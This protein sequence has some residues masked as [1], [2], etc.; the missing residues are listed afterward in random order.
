MKN[1]IIL[2]ILIFGTTILHANEPI[3][4]LLK[5]QYGY[6][7]IPFG[8]EYRRSINGALPENTNPETAVL[9]SPNAM[10]RLF[11]DGKGN[12][13]YTI[14]REYPS[15]IKDKPF[16]RYIY[17]LSPND[18]MKYT[19]EREL[20]EI[21]D[22]DFDKNRDPFIINYIMGF[23]SP[24]LGSNFVNINKILSSREN[25]ISINKEKDGVIISLRIHN[26]N[27]PDNK[28][29]RYYIYT[30]V[31]GNI[32]GKL[33]PLKSDTRLLVVDEN[34]K[35][36]LLPIM[37]EILYEDYI[38]VGKSDIYMPKRILVRRYEIITESTNEFK[39]KLFEQET[40]EITK[41]ISDIDEIEKSM[42][43]TIPE[44]TIL[45]DRKNGDMYSFP[46]IINS[47]KKSMDAK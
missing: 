38:K 47:I 1:F 32:S 33:Y 29:N 46:G 27:T 17:F 30:L 34:G 37:A 25:N 10:C 19:P 22:N 41:I 2:A 44:S 45:F 36:S 8:V 21:L 42:S 4:S 26:G 3:L 35:E 6:R 31:L 40:I 12:Y 39:Q 15:G 43:L 5:G 9:Y 14:D 13:L 24:G 16:S 18:T 23:P 20:I 7:S 28:Y 11:A